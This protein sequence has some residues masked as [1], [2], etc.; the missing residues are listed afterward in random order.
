MLPAF[1][2]DALA[3]RREV[4]DHGGGRGDR[5][6]HAGADVARRRAEMQALSRMTARVRTHREIRGLGTEK[7]DCRTQ[8]VRFTTRR[9]HPSAPASKTR[10][11]VARALAVTERSA[12]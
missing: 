6:R 9:W 1:H 3:R 7:V 11:V 2:R 4:V 8:T 12:R 5:R 10:R